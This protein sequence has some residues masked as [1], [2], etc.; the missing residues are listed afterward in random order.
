MS[1]LKVLSS[2]P[3]VSAGPSQQSRLLLMLPVY[4]Q[5]AELEALFRS[6]EG[7]WKFSVLAVDDGSTDDSIALLEDWLGRR[8]VIRHVRNEGYGAAICSGLKYALRE[9]YDFLLSFD[10]DLQHDA[11]FI[12]PFLDLAQTADIISGS[13]YLPASPRLSQTPKLREMGDRLYRHLLAAFT[14]LVLTDVWCGMR[15]VR[16]AAAERLSIRSTGYEYPLEFWPSV[17]QAGLSVREVAVPLIYYDRDFLR[18]SDPTVLRDRGKLFL[19]TFIQTVRRVFDVDPRRVGDETQR[20]LASGAFPF[21][22]GERAV[23][24]HVVSEVIAGR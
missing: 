23:I 4:N 8:T 22:T 12:A 21:E 17:A 18:D 10:A 24:Q 20:A 19:R 14:P 3:P 1:D 11:R 13:R 6:L 2:N 5:V 15:L 16:V 7:R 9:K